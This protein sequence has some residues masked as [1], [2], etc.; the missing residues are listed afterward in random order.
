MNVIDESR[1][2][3]KSDL[4]KELRELNKIINEDTGSKKPYTISELFRKKKM[5]ELEFRSDKE[6][7]DYFSNKKKLKANK[8]QGN[9]TSNTLVFY[10]D[11]MTKLFSLIPLE[12]LKKLE[13]LNLPAVCVSKYMIDRIGFIFF[14]KTK[15]KNL[16]FI[17][18]K[19]D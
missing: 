18:R 17:E 8:I 11:Y 6:T 19:K 2:E 16:S 15:M 13:L 5:R 1:L 10:I 3:G 14:H 12:L 9:I 4:K 7:T